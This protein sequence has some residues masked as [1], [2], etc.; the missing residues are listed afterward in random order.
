MNNFLKTIGFALVASALFSGQSHAG[1]EPL[2]ATKVTQEDL[3]NAINNG[4]LAQIQELGNI[5]NL[6]S[7]INKA[8]RTPLQQV[9]Y[10]AKSLMDMAGMAS[11]F[12]PDIGQKKKAY[13]DIINYL[14]AQGAKEKEL[15]KNYA[16]VLAAAKK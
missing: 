8:G 2:K 12:N 16:D 10:Y 13:F 5:Q 4:S 14:L 3:F 15:M 11:E 6:V 1:Y 7:K 9:A